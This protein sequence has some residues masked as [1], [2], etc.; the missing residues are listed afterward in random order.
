MKTPVK[1]L[2][3]FACLF[4]LLLAAPSAE[5]TGCNAGGNVFSLS[6]PVVAPQAF[7]AHPFAAAAVA[8][9]AVVVPRRTPVRNFV[10]SQRVIVPAQPFVSRRG[11]LVI[12]F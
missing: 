7:V 10:F 3:A 12:G 11:R 6:A 9:Q 2:A 1:L 8:P 4:A 5:A